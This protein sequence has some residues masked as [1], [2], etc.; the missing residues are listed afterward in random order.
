VKNEGFYFE[1]P[2]DSMVVYDITW[3]SKTEDVKV[4][5]ADALHVPI[6]AT[7][8]Y[9]PKRSDLY[10][11]AIELGPTYYKDVIQP[12]FLTL[13][14]SEFAKYEHNEL[15]IKSPEI[16]AAIT[17]KLRTALRGKPLE[18]DHVAISHIKFDPNV[19]SAISQKRATA[20]RVE[21][22][23]SEVEIA[24]KDAEIARTRAQG[25]A[26]AI[27]I[28]ARGEAEA[29]VVKGKAQAEAQDAIAKTL[30][31]DYLRYKAFD[32]QTTRYYFVPVG[33]DGMPLI[34]NTDPRR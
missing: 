9:R 31:A 4:L 11:L 2:W 29:I 12:E 15:A 3:H 23:A 25:S 22:K 20:E 17:K 6:S 26:D 32:S 10:R 28:G 19:T 16:E 21:Q 8:T 13:A 24:K 7:V 18:I 34:I 27:R 30:T 33:K 5:T 14:R 1:W